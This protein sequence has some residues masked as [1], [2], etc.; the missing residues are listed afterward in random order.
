MKTISKTAFLAMVA[1][2]G[3][4][5]YNSEVVSNGYSLFPASM[6]AIEVRDFLRLDPKAIE[7]AF[8][9]FGPQVAVST[10]TPK[11]VDLVRRE[12]KCESR[13]VYWRCAWV[14]LEK[15]LDAAFYRAEDGTDLI[16]DADYAR[17]FGFGLGL[18][19]YGP[20]DP[21]RNDDGTVLCMPRRL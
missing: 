21:V 14:P 19:G 7:K 10:L 9:F 18:I 1:K 17:A 12:P 2:S 6:L 11:E 4:L 13:R 20:L 3:T 16:L 15:E 8:A 5:R